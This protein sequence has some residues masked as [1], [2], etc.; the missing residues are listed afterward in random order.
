MSQAKT[1]AKSKK[2]KLIGWFLVIAPF[3]GLVI[4]LMAY[5][6]VSFVTTSMID[7]GSEVHASSMVETVSQLM[8]VG[9]GFFGVFCVLGILV[10]VPVGIYYLA[11]EY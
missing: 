10:A 11:Q 7:S 4:I 1:E 2:N 8:R 5:S 3:A 9:L 6:I